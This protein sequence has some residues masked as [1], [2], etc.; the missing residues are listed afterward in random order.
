MGGV[1]AIMHIGFNVYSSKKQLLQ[2]L[3]SEIH[4]TGEEQYK[5]EE[6]IVHNL[7]LTLGREMNLSRSHCNIYSPLKDKCGSYEVCQR[8]SSFQEEQ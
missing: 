3:E 5:D 1:T 7:T 8:K 4:S 6:A 2:P